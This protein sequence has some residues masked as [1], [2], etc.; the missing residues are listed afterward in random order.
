LGDKIDPACLSVEDDRVFVSFQNMQ[1]RTATQRF[2]RCYHDGVWVASLPFE[3][4][5]IPRKGQ[6]LRITNWHH[7][8]PVKIEMY[9]KKDKNWET[10]FERNEL[11]EGLHCLADCA[12][13][14]SMRNIQ[15]GRISGNTV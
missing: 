2:W 5:K 15:E 1:I 8:M 7:G 14:H 10:L 3:L 9:H 12:S 4:S 11:P 6:R 13:K